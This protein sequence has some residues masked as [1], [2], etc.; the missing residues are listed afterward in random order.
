MSDHVARRPAGTPSGGQFARRRG[1]APDLELAAAMSKTISREVSRLAAA[2][3]ERST[4]RTP[5]PNS[6]ADLR[7]PRPA[8]TDK[9]ATTTIDLHRWLTDHDAPAGTADGTFGPRGWT[10]ALAPTLQPFVGDNY[11][12][13]AYTERPDYC[14]GGRYENGLTGLVN[15]DGVDQLAARQLL[16]TL[17]ASV[18]D[19]SH[20]HA[21]K[22]RRLLRAA[23]ENPHVRLGGYVVPPGRQDER[24]SFDS[25]TVFIETAD[26]VTARDEICKMI[27]R[28]DDLLE[29]DFL[30]RPIEWRDGIPGWRVWWD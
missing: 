15:F 8:D 12:P 17:P 3:A 22:A 28:R 16:D 19:D 25:M 11:I 30:C 5:Q 21:P 13:W 23:A 27:G 9:Q 14:G 26:P 29:D 2:S 24:V 10:K 1:A 4:H 6:A 18:L 20:N 7:P